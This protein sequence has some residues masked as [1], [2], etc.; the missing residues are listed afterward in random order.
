MVFG[1]YNNI[2]IQPL[3]YGGK[4]W[5]GMGVTMISELYDWT[6]TFL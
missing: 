1:F 2:D 3:V 5:P 6:M 4:E